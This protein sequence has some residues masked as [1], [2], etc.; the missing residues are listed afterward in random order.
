MKHMSLVLFIHKR[1]KNNDMTVITYLGVKILALKIDLGRTVMG[2]VMGSTMG[3]ISR[4]SVNETHVS[5][6]FYIQMCRNNGMRVHMWKAM[7]C[8]QDKKM[9]KWH[10]RFTFL[11]L[12]KMGKNTRCGMTRV[13]CVPFQKEWNCSDG[14]RWHQNTAKGL[15]ENGHWR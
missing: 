6:P 9:F 3:G 2:R 14:P 11:I 12:Q 5:F 1:V 7:S 15:P 4:F 13:A 8:I 10:S